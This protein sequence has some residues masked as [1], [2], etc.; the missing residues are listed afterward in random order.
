ML[1]KKVEFGASR[2]NLLE[3]GLKIRTNNFCKKFWK[4]IFDISKKIFV[5]QKKKKNNA[6]IEKN[7]FNS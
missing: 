3:Y 1:D 6:N 4:V 7:S 2:K 5:F